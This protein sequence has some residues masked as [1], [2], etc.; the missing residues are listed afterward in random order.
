MFVTTDTTGGLVGFRHQEVTAAQAR[1]GTC[2]IEAAA[3]D[4]GGVKAALAEAAGD[5]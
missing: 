5:E 4:E 2:G 3:D 1:V